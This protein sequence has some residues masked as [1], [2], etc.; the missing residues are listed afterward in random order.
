MNVLEREVLPIMQESGDDWA[1][2]N[3]WGRI[4]DIDVA[5]GKLDEALSILQNDLVPVFE[6]LGD[7]HSLL[8]ARTKIAIRSKR[9]TSRSLASRWAAELFVVGTR[10]EKLRPAS[11]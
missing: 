10:A 3:A 4:A 6:R 1:I 5:R 8:V 11:E 2:A 9:S 7:V